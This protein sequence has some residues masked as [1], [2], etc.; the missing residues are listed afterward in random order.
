MA[1]LS[2]EEL[3]GI[4]PNVVSVAEG[5]DFVFLKMNSDLLFTLYSSVQ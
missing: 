4:V 5:K 1:C 3:I 2:F